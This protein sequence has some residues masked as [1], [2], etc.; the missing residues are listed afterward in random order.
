MIAASLRMK[1]VHVVPLSAPALQI[2]KRRGILRLT[3]DGLLF[4]TWPP[5]HF[6]RLAAEKTKV[7]KE[8]VD[9]S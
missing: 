9:K 7:P 1:K 3:D 4:S 6:H 8:V 2:L 5:K